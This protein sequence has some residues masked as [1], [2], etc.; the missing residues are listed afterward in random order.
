[1]I[2][3]VFPYPV[4]AASLVVMWMLLNSFSPGHLLLGVL[5]AL[6][7]SHAMAAL[8]PAKP[9]FRRWDLIP[10]LFGLVM[11][12]ILRSNV[13]VCRIVLFGARRERVSGFVAIPLELRDRNGLAILSCIVTS[14]PGTAWIEYDSAAGVL[15]IHVLDLK[16]EEEWIELIGGRYAGL[17]MEIFE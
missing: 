10:R 1:M 11:L 9:H 3:R 12:D 5:V 8:Q 4:L 17:L 7:A 6:I 14:T 13:A 2:S 15:L 16:N